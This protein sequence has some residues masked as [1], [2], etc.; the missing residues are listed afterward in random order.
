MND[1]YGA[2]KEKYT[3]TNENSDPQPRRFN[4]VRF[5]DIKMSTSPIALVEGLIPR[6]GLTVVWGPPKCGKTFW[7]FDLAMHIALGWE[8]RGR[9]VEKVNGAVVYVSC[10]GEPGL[11]QRKEAFRKA[12]LEG[13]DDPNF[14]LISTPA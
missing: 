5:K 3:G 13:K 10:E 4:L 9:H 8:Y 1:T 14:Y 6:E 7:V 12:K 2:I 11:G